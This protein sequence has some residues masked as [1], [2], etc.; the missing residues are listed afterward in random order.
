[1]NR[2]IFP[3]AFGL[4]LL[5][6]PALADPCKAIPD[7]G[8]APSW[9]KPGAQFAGQV[10]YVGDGDSICVGNSSNPASW[11]EVRL[12]DWYAPE[13]NEP[14]GQQAKAAMSRIAQGRAVTCTVQQGNNGRVISYD[15]VI[16]TCRL[17]GRS[18]RDFMQSAGVRE[19]GRGQ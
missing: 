2:L 10:R 6:S 4:A 13:L 19:G 9:I 12:A 5:A 11:V 17:N 1:M 16:A 8:P 3:A 18:L 15:R 14:G 7:R